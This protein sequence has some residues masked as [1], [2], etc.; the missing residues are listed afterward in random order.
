MY[1]AILQIMEKEGGTLDRG[2]LNDA[3]KKLYDEGYVDVRFKGNWPPKVPSD[4]YNYEYYLTEK[5]KQT[6]EGFKKRSDYI[7]NYEGK[8]DATV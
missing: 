2:A 3:M 8:V 7:K 1:S 6:L 5:G 4:H